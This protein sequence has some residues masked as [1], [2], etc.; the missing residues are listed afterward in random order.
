MTPEQCAEIL[1]Q[2]PDYKVLRRLTEHN[3]YLPLQP[4][5]VL[6]RG[7]IL[8]TETTGLSSEAD[9]IIE[10]GMLVFDF[11][12]ITG[13]IYR[14]VES[15]DQLEDPGRP[16]PPES[17]QVHHITDDMVRGQRIDDAEVRRLL[18][19]VRVVIAHN[20]AFDRPFVEQR[21]S[22]FEDVFWACSLR[23]IDWQGEGFGSAK[24]EYL[25]Y[26]QGIF[27]EAHRAE[28][29]CRALLDILSRSLPNS[30]KPALLSL[31]ESLNQ[32]QTRVYALNSP[33][34]TKD[35][36]KLRGYRWD[37]EMRCWH[38]TLSGDQA[39]TEETAWLKRRVY[40]ERKAVIEVETLGGRVR[41]S[42]RAGHREK[43][44]L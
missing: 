44:A 17:T 16:I 35:I 36:L 38:R 29:D 19:D 43:I 14:I 28:N 7:L 34:E 12:P 3:Q 41:Y 31:L 32:P 9:R 5:L 11:D 33:F 8:D 26:T 1:E 39:L 22:E 25:L 10:L 21:W 30:Q 42:Q 4:G 27:Y 6:T 20:A 13:L 37:G 18:K 23:D 15:F 2:H 40:G 24:L